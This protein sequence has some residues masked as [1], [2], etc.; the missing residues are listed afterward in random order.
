MCVIFSFQ[1]FP[2][3]GFHNRKRRLFMQTVWRFRPCSR[4][5]F[6]FATVLV[7]LLFLAGCGAVIVQPYDAGLVDKTEA[8]YRKGAEMIMQGWAVS[9]KTDSQRAAMEASGDSPATFSHFEAQY[10]GLILDTEILILRAMSGSMDIGAAGEKIQNRVEELIQA[11]VPSVCPDL[12][13][14]FISIS[15]TAR[16]Y[17]DLKCL[18]LRWKEQHR[19]RGILKKANWEG[20]KIALFDIIYAI[21][22]AESFKKEKETS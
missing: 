20:R 16:N 3:L 11:D 4:F 6:R 12:Q 15:L 14:Q 18:F 19:E 22:R 2:V 10:D 5:L 7:L 1:G 17:V 8:I 13:E 21:D 9:P